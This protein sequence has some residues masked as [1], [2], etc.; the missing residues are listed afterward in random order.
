M[1]G[2]RVRL[3]KKLNCEDFDFHR[4]EI[5]KNNQLIVTMGPYKT[6]RNIMRDYNKIVNS[7]KSKSHLNECYK[8]LSLAEK[9]LLVFDTILSIVLNRDTD[10][11]KKCHYH[12]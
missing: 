6:N 10:Y 11:C 1:K 9:W 4:I 3:F 8:I 12:I 2:E 7:W 5:T